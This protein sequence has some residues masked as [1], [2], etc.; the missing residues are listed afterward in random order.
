VGCGRF[1]WIR[2]NA[3]AQLHCSPRVAACAIAAEGLAISSVMSAHDQQPPSFSP[4]WAPQIYQSAPGRRID[5]WTEYTYAEHCIVE[6]DGRTSFQ[7]G[8]A[9][10]WLTNDARHLPPAARAPLVAPVSIM[11]PCILIRPLGATDQQLPWQSGAPVPT[12]LA[13]PNGAPWWRKVLLLGGPQK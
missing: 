3:T 9:W 8:A 12:Q 1:V 6:P 4:A 2:V 13:L 10:R 5:Q 11:R 7:W